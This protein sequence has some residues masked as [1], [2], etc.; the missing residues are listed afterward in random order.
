[1]YCRGMTIVYFDRNVFADIC[2][3]RRGLTGADVAKL[4]QAVSSG[5]IMIPISITLI[6]E[7]LKIL[8]SSE[9]SYSQHM[10]TLLR[11]V[12]PAVMVKHHSILILEDCWSYAMNQPYER[13]IPTSE[14]FKSFLDLT[15]NKEDLI[16]LAE[17][18]TE[19]YKDSASFITENLLTTRANNEGA[20]RPADFQ[21]LWKGMAEWIISDICLP[22]CSRTV[23]RLCKKYDLQHML[24]IRSLRIFTIYFAWLTYT[25][26]F[27]IENE[28]RKV[29][30]G[31]VG[32]WYHA[33]QSSAADIFVTQENKN[34]SG[35][36]PYILN[37]IP[38]DGFE[39]L[40]LQ[41]FLG[42]I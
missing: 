19:S 26:W 2:E 24:E 39:V 33:I 23:R 37:Q 41:E 30:T 21:D 4:E 32:D 22:S 3:L 29:R 36:L 40:S 16:T 11:F 13:L 15:K 1:M 7:T 27:G 17:M 42:G 14:Q 20:T 6:E 8:R 18:I 31:E 25:G 10:E 28:P 9:D 12:D 38:I 35:K 34:Q 5:S